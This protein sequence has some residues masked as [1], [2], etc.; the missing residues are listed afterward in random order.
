MG[1]R[2]APETEAAWAEDVRHG[3]RGQGEGGGTWKPGASGWQSR[4]QNNQRRVGEGVPTH[5]REGRGESREGARLAAPS[6]CRTGDEELGEEGSALSYY[7]LTA[8]GAEREVNL[9][10]RNPTQGCTPPLLPLP[11]TE[12]SPC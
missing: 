6:S 2:G 8:F 9:R 7:L 4:L 12:R 10:Y 1:G 11:E 3:A 5:F